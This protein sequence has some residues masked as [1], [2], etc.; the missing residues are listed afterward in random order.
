VLTFSQLITN[1]YKICD[2]TSKH[3]N[4]NNDLTNCLCN[5]P[6]EC[7]HSVLVVCCSLHLSTQ[8]E[9]EKCSNDKDDENLQSGS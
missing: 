1:Q 6:A 7:K 9:D 5:W 4:Y 2:V 3:I 8:A